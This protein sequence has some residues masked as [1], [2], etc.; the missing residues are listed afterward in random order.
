MTEGGVEHSHVERGLLQWE[1]TRVSFDEP[2]VREGFE[3]SICLTSV[4]RDAG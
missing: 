4:R 3:P 1:R 2:E